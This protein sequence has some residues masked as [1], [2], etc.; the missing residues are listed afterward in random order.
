MVIGHKEF[1][2]YKKGRPSKNNT[3]D[4][5]CCKLINEDISS[6]LMVYVG[7]TSLERNKYAHEWKCKQNIYLRDFKTIYQIKEW[8]ISGRCITCQEHAFQSLKNMEL[9]GN[10]VYDTFVVH[11]LQG[12][13]EN[14]SH[15]MFYTYI[16]R[17]IREDQ[18]RI[19]ANKNC[20]CYP[21]NLD[22]KNEYHIIINKIVTSNHI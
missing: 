11:N 21:K 2:V 7:C 22:P 9:R 8:V 13:P 15:D 19:C 6:Q 14:V 1:F 12:K 20:A 18:I 3:S 4:H 5:D 10:L 17:I 16:T